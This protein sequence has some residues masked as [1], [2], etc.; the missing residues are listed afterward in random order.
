M[1]CQYTIHIE[2]HDDTSIDR[3]KRMLNIYDESN[4]V[5][6]GDDDE[7][8]SVEHKLSDTDINIIRQFECLLERL[9]LEDNIEWTTNPNEG[10]KSFRN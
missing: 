9:T 10:G 8:G 7:C 2:V 5:D 3:A 1:K 6:I 4:F